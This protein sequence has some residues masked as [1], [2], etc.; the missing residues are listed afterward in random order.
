MIR[1][2]VDVT[3]ESLPIFERG[4]VCGELHVVEVVL[5]LVASPPAAARA[6]PGPTEP[7]RVEA[8]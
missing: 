2:K 8:R 5:A 3:F 1:I 4:E 7:V 6:L